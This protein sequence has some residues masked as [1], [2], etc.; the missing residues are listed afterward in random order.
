MRS[1]PSAHLHGSVL[2]SRTFAALFVVALSARV[3][4]GLFRIVRVG[5]GLEF[6]DEEGY[7]NLAASL[8]RHGELVGEHGFRAMRMPL[9]P[10]FLSA[11]THFDHGIGAAKAAHWLIGSATAVLTG[12]LGARI[13]G[14]RVGTIA[15]LIVAIDPFQVFFSSLLLTETPFVAALVGF[16][17]AMWPLVDRAGETYPAAES[18]GETRPTGD[19][20]RRPATGSPGDCRPQWLGWAIAGVVGAICVYLRESSLGLVVAALMMAAVGRRHG[21]GR[22]FIGAIVAVALIVASLA[23]W[24]IRNNRVTGQT[25]W[26]TNRGGISLYDGVGPQAPGASNLADIKQMSAVRGLSETEWNEYFRRESWRFIRDEPGRILRLAFIKMAR[27][28]NPLP[29]AESYQSRLFRV[30]SAGWMLPIY[31]LTVVGVVNVWSDRKTAIALLF[32]AAYFTL[33]HAV[34]VGSMRYRLPAMPFLEILA[35]IGLA[36]IIRLQKARPARDPEWRPIP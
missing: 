27:T 6:P 24:A 3:A 36:A 22:A 21:R 4:W 25:C 13:G 17:L 32:P 23:P 7:W 34:F 30:V 35:A 14:R 29:N 19:A 10:G 8:A 9:Y 12:V 16:G 1:G 28:W 11:F 18:A 2:S 20:A 31:V 33:V 5:G 26:L 15:G